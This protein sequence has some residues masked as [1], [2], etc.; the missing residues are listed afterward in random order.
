M[1]I[2]SARLQLVAMSGL[3]LVL[4]G[5]STASEEVAS[6]QFELTET[7]VFRGYEF[8]VDYPSGWL[9][10][11]RNSVTFI[12][13]LEED[14][15]SALR[16]EEYDGQGYQISFDYRSMPFMQSIGLPE[17]P[18]LDDL[19]E[20]NMGFFDWQE[21]IDIAEQEIFG[22]PAYSV[23]RHDDSSWG[24][25]LMGLRDGEAFLLAFNASSE[26]AKD[27]FLPTWAKMIQSISPTE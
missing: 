10:D 2:Q 1:K 16:E 8:S 17:S 12:S 7:Y 5:C 20:L 18:T 21:P 26:E 24:V 3:V 23:D 9:A 13:E 11:S 4:A 15:E 6:T 25:S 14:H 27:A 22:V 19:L